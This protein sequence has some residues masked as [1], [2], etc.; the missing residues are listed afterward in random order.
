MPAN[1]RRVML[2]EDDERIRRVLDIALRGEGYRVMQ[3]G[4]GAPALAKLAEVPADVVVLDL[5]LPDID[6][7]EVCRRLRRTSDV[8][9]IVISA[10]GDSHDVVAGLEAGADDYMIKPV[11][12]KELSARIRALLRRSRGNE[13]TS[14]NTVAGDLEVRPGEGVV[15]RGGEP[16]QLTTTE[17]RLLEELAERVGAVVRRETLLE[18]VW[19]YDF[20]GDSRLVDVHVSRLRS[21][22]EDDPGNPRHVVTV[23]GLGYKLAP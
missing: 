20:F 3:A 14:A 2:V 5:M 7:F 22:I 17:L 10:R 12:A 6:G 11:V 9:V 18:R 1:G 8:P 4:A 13:P 23:R 21:K 19:G 15:L 16:V